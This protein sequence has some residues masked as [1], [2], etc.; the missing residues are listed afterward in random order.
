MSKAIFRVSDPNQWGGEN[1]LIPF[2]E[3]IKKLIFTWRKIYAARES[4]PF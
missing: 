1:L 4:C 2:S 3:E